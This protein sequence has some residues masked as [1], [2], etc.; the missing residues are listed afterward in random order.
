MYFEG[1][2]LVLGLCLALAL[3][4]VLVLALVLDFSSFF[5]CWSSWLSLVLFCPSSGSVL[6]S[7]PC[8]DSGNCNKNCVLTFCSLGYGRKG[9]KDCMYVTYPK[10]PTVKNTLAVLANF[11]L[12]FGNFPSFLA[13]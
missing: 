2:V 10:K 4:I 13:P 3:F 8:S 12:D 9:K 1:L 7:C 6:S 5:G 11:S